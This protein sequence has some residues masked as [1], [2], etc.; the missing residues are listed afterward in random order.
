MS[1]R[2]AIIKHLACVALRI[3]AASG[4]ILVVCFTL[5]YLYGGLM[6]LSLLMLSV[7]CKVRVL[8]CVGRVV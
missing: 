2:G 4:A 7:S 5:Y 1:L 6:A 8:V 3:W